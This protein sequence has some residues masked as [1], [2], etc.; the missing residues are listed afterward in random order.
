MSVLEIKQSLSRL[1]EKE[2]REIQV[3]L[4]QLR[5]RSPSWEKATAKR[6]A[7]MQNGQ[8]TEVSTLEKRMARGK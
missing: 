7:E 6:I 1:S 8:F 5:R 2:R 3:Y 4:L